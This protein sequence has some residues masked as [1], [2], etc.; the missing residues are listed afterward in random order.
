[1]EQEIVLELFDRY[2]DLVYRIALGYLRSP[3]E[4]ERAA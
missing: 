4:A 2:A 3:Q 1:M